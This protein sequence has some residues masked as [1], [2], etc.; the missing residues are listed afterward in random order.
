MSEICTNTYSGCKDG[1]GAM[2]QVTQFVTTL[3]E[4]GPDSIPGQSMLDFLWTN[5]AGAGF[6]TITSVFTCQ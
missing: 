1:P 5:D 6:S 3:L 2:S 4:E